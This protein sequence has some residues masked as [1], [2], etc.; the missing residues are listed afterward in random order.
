M[1]RFAVVA[2]L[3]LALAACG[4]AAATYTFNGVLAKKYRADQ[5]SEPLRLVFEVSLN[6][7]KAKTIEC[8]VKNMLR[9]MW[10][11]LSV[12]A[13]VT[14]QKTST[15]KYKEGTFCGLL[16]DANVKDVLDQAGK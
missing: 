2:L 14:F 5:S 16:N 12:G 7:G 8:R 1:I 10:D 11:G 9:P 6:K 15:H 13:K 3:V 4:D